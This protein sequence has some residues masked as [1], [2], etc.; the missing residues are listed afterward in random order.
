M[1]GETHRTT[2]RHLFTMFAAGGGL[3]TS[4]SSSAPRAESQSQQPA[5]FTKPLALQLYTVRD[6]IKG[7]PNTVLKRIAAIGYTEVEVIRETYASIANILKAYKLRPISGHLEASLV[8]HGDQPVAS[9]VP[10]MT[11][12][13]AVEQLRFGGCDYAVLPFIPPEDRGGIDA[14]KRIAEKMNKAGQI[15][16]N[17]ELRFVY[18]H[19]AFEFAPMNGT[20]PMEILRQNIDPKLVGFEVDVF[21]LHRAGQDP[22]SYIRGLKGQVHL[23]HLKD[24]PKDLPTAP[25]E[26]VPN[27]SF[28]AVGKGFL[29]LPGILRAAEEAGVQYYIVEQDQCPGDPVD[30]ARTSFENLRAMRL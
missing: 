24:A 25:N 5:L 21:W 18:H 10:Q 30:S 19:H 9:A 11:L 7:D 12:A 27:D 16:A 1:S 14:Y 22:A 23:V 13:A 20:T 15:C 6:V 17:G 8:L 26:D 28:L 4:C 3:L 2:R 29:D